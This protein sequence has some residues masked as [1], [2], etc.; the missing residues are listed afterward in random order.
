MEG[1]EGEGEK[2]GKGRGT[3]RY[4]RPCRLGRRWRGQC[5]TFDEEIVL[6]SPGVARVVAGKSS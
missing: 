5:L 4:F 1:Q 2:S 3:G 6:S